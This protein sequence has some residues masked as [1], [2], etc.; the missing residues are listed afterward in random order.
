NAFGT[1]HRKHVSMYDVPMILG[2]GQR[3]CGNLVAKELK[4]LGDALSKPQRPFIAILGGAN[5]SD[6]IGV[7]ES[8]LPKVDLIL[9]GGAMSYTFLA[10]KGMTIGKS[11]C[12]KDKL[13]LARSL[14]D[15]AGDKIKLP[16]DSVCAAEIKS[17]VHTEIHHS[18]IPAGFMGLDIGPATI[19][20]YSNEIRNGR[21]I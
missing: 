2:P 17:G 4:F 13:D 15:K 3:V 10:A 16:A 1:C 5:V 20:Q 14:L 6:K 21:T 12:E 19:D 18:S 11:L 8:L 9:I 7:I